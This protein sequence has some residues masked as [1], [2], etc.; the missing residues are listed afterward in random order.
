MGMN[1]LDC[2]GSGRRGVVEPAVAQDEVLHLQFPHMH[3]AADRRTRHHADAH[4]PGQAPH[5]EGEVA[6]VVAEGDLGEETVGGRRLARDVGRRV[7]GV[8]PL[9]LDVQTRAD[10]VAGVFCA[11]LGDLGE[12]PHALAVA[13]GRVEVQLIRAREAVRGGD[14]HV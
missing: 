2:S 10:H 14:P 1:H 4:Q 12:V 3:G 11:F 9:V 13:S 5:R 8:G 7:S 6:A